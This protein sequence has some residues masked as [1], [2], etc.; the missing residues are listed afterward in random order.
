MDIKKKSTLFHSL[1]VTF[2]IVLLSWAILVVTTIVIVY[3]HYRQIAEEYNLPFIL[4]IALS[5]KVFFLITGWNSIYRMTRRSLFTHVYSM[6]PLVIFA[7]VMMGSSMPLLGYIL[8]PAE[9][10]HMLLVYSLIEKL[11]LEATID[12]RAIDS[13]CLSVPSMSHG[14]STP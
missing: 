13:K 2:F 6:Y 11:P 3:H 9:A 12:S 10:L 1:Y 8:S 14:L 4:P 7:L 5:Y